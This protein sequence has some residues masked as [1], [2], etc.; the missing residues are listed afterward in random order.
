MITIFLGL[1]HFHFPGL[2]FLLCAVQ[3]ATCVLFYFN[4][5][6]YYFNN[7]MHVNATRKLVY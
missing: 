1:F 5:F 3:D 4:Y 6:L 2:I 7:D